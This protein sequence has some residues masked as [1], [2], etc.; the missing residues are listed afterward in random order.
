MWCDLGLGSFAGTGIWRDIIWFLLQSVLTKSNWNLTS[1]QP[2]LV[3]PYLTLTAPGW[4]LMFTPFI[5]T[6]LAWNS[7][8]FLIHSQITW[9]PNLKTLKSHFK[10]FFF[11]DA[12]P[13]T[14]KQWAKLQWPSWKTDPGI[15]LSKFILSFGTVQFHIFVRLPGVFSVF[16]WLFGYITHF[17][18]TH[19]PVSAVLISELQ[20][21]VP[22][23]S[24]R[25]CPS[26]PAMRR[27][28][29]QLFRLLR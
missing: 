5:W 2:F 3:L 28:A 4:K 19:F 20:A 7:A 22:M 26:K 29:G 27:A 14:I 25:A 15:S 11:E 9:A 6:F 18:A 12:R 13:G 10:V 24:C 16:F 23:H 17:P 1:S 8:A 21:W